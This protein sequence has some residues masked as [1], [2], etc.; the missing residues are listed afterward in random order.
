MKNEPMN[1][2]T[3]KQNVR[4]QEEDAYMWNRWICRRKTGG[5]D[6]ARR[7][8]EAGIPRIWFRRIAVR[9]ENNAMSR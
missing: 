1:K 2:M 3:L 8:L 6:F 9:D 7:T 4:N 5:T